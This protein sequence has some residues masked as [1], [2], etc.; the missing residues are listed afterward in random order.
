VKWY[1]PLEVLLE[2]W[3]FAK[4]DANQSKKHA[5]D[6][7]PIGIPSEGPCEWNFV[8]RGLQLERLSCTQVS[9]YLW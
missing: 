5:I 3:S 6:T 8:S 2:R 4:N 7:I 9:G 1:S